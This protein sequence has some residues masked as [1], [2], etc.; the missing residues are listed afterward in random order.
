MWEVFLAP[1]ILSH[2]NFPEMGC[3]SF[4]WGFMGII[5]IVLL[6][7]QHEA[8]TLT[9]QSDWR[10]EAMLKLPFTSLIYEH[11]CHFFPGH[12]ARLIKWLCSENRP[13]TARALMPEYFDQGQ[14]FHLIN[15]IE[16][17]QEELF[18]LDS[19]L[20]LHA[21]SPNI[22][23]HLHSWSGTK[24]IGV[25]LV[26][27]YPGVAAVLH[28]GFQIISTEDFNSFIEEEKRRN[29]PTVER[30]ERLRGLHKELQ[31]LQM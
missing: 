10:T 1:I 17:K 28:T 22:F 14:P 23:R 2:F 8:Y 29:T 3:G 27:N 24:R 21:N 9:A 26:E 15:I 25:L 6:Y 12:C 5:V 11:E 18:V 16:S 30:T 19:L 7:H 31:H 13:R 20:W 4:C